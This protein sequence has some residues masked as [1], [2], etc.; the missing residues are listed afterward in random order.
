MSAKPAR[1][2]RVSRLVAAI[3]LRLLDGGGLLGK[4]LMVAGTHAMYAYEAA[5][6]FSGSI[7]KPEFS[8]RDQ[9]FPRSGADGRCPRVG[10]TGVESGFVDEASA[11]AGFGGVGD[12][13]E[14]PGSGEGF[15]GFG[16]TVADHDLVG[17]IG[18]GVGEGAQVGLD[19]LADAV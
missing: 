4:N 13:V 18:H 12:W 15:Q 2:D 7:P 16:G 11:G 1:L 10:H 3:L 19:L 17:R 5:A 6:G 8:A 14:A 9:G